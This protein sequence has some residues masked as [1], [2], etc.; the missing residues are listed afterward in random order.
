MDWIKTIKTLLTIKDIYGKGAKVKK[1]HDYAKKQKPGKLDAENL[2]FFR[3]S[4]LEKAIAELNTYESKL[5]KALKEKIE[6]PESGTVSLFAKWLQTANKNGEQS[7]E[8]RKAAAA[9]AK[10]LEAYQKRMKDILAAL[11]TEQAKLPEKISFSTTMAE[12][13]KAVH[14][15]YMKFAQTPNPFIPGTAWQAEMFSLAQ[16][17]QRYSGMMRSINTRLKKLS[18]KNAEVIS[19][20]EA[21]MKNNA[22]WIKSAQDKAFGNPD[23]LKKNEKAT[24]PKK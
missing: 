8:A 9:Y 15:L 13:S 4:K 7:P 6:M 16:D 17:V 23:T 3:N 19:N 21:L 2:K 5:D 1:L 24:K 10:G 14:D 22:E 20:L 18:A 11:K 12:Y